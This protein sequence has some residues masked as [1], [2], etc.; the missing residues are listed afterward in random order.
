MMRVYGSFWHCFEYTPLF[1]GPCG[2]ALDVPAIGASRVFFECMLVRV[3]VESG[4][5]SPDSEVLHKIRRVGAAHGSS[6]FIVHGVPGHARGTDRGT[7]VHGSRD[8]L[9]HVADTLDIVSELT[10]RLE[11]YGERVH[12]M[13]FG[14]TLHY[15]IREGA[16][17]VVPL[18]KDHVPE[19]PVA[20]PGLSIAQL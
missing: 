13:P 8:V 18:R 20:A 10:E 7:A 11:E 19:R 3:V 2:I 4:D 17:P 1:P 5:R 12:L 9:E 16:G 15:G 14:W 6:Y